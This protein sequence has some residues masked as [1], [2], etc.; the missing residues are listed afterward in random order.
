M[1]TAAHPGRNTLSVNSLGDLV[2]N[3]GSNPI[4]AVGN[5]FQVGGTTLTAVALSFTTVSTSRA[6]TIPGQSITLTATVAAGATGSAAPGG[7]V[8]FYDSSTDTDLGSVPLTGG[9]ATLSTSALGFGTH[10]IQALYSGDA[11]FGPSLGTVTQTVKQSVYVLNKTAAGA[12]TVSGDAS[13]DLAG[14]VVVN[15]RSK[16][17]VSLSGDAQIDAARIEVVGGVDRGRHATLGSAPVTGIAPVDDPLAGLAAPTGGVRRGPVDLTH[18][19]LTI[20]PGVYYSIRVSGD[21]TLTLRPGVYVIEGGGLTVSGNGSINGSGVMIYNAGGDDDRGGITLSGNGT[22]NL[23]AAT[24]G[25]YAGVVLFQARDDAR[26]ISL[27]GK[28]MMGL[29]G[30]IYAPA[31]RLSLKGRALI[32]DALVVGELLLMGDSSVS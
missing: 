10:V 12:L 16:D 27:S 21:A 19:S 15:S 24:S 3:T 17:A 22:F 4:S 28:A 9:V 25:P 29:G 32:L 8:D 13:L 26:T 1:G 11:N 7:L 18:G 23:T 2:S 31:A 30:T 5:T 6:T 14:D 20:N